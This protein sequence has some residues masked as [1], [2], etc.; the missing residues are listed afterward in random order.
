MTILIATSVVRGAHQGESHGGV[1]L[2]DIE[3]ERV[4]QTIDWN[5][6]NIDWQGR[7]WDRGLRGIAF[8]GDRVFIAASDELFEY[9]PD[10]SL[11]ASYRNKYLKHC[12]EICCHKR[13]LFLSSTGFDSILGFDLDN[14]RFSFGLSLSDLGNEFRGSPFNPES[15]QGPQAHNSLHV[16]NIVCNSDAMY[17]SGLRTRGLLEYTGQH[18]KKLIELP[19]GIHNARPYEEGILFNDT[20]SDVVRYVSKA[21][22]HAF[23][24]PRYDEQQLTHRELGDDRIARQ[25]F[26]RGLCNLDDGIIATGSSPSTITLHNLHTLKTFK[27]ITLSFDIRN[28]IHGLEVW[29]YD[30]IFPAQTNER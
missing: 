28:S 29:P 5:T 19:E 18:I 30:F 12:H 7:G 6:A 10:F 2:V 13:R 8:D 22:Q 9:T 17:V 15:D 21:G 3:H 4:V 23:K 11:V 14:N 20:E 27:Q 1:Y 26:G 16:N 24:I 25:G